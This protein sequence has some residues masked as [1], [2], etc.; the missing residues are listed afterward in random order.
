M[1]S[2]P[3]REITYVFDDVKSDSSIVDLAKSGDF[4]AIYLDG[5][6]TTRGKSSVSN[7]LKRLSATEEESISIDDARDSVG[8][9]IGVFEKV[10][11]PSTYVV[12]ADPF[13]YQPVFYRQI[14][15]PGGRTAFLVSNSFRSI[16]ARAKALGAT[17]WISW[18]VFFS[19]IGTS[20]AWSITMQSHQTLEASTFVLLPG[21]EIVVAED[22]WAIKNTNFFDPGAEDYHTLVQ[23]GVAKAVSQLKAASNIPVDQ[24]NIYLSGGRD[25]RMAI[26]LLAAAGVVTEYSVSTVNPATWTP[27]SARPGLYRDLFVANTIRESFGMNWTAHRPATN[28]PLSFQNSLEFWQSNRSHKNFRFRAQQG[29][30]VSNHIS[31]EIRGAAGETFRGFQAVKTLKSYTQF[32]ASGSTRE[33]DIHLLTEELFGQGILTGDSLSLAKASVNNS[34]AKTGGENIIDALHRRYSVYRNRSHFG[35]VKAS[36]AT[37]Q[38]PILPLSQP[39]FVKAASL[40]SEDERYENAMAFDI[41]ELA[42]PDLNTLEFDSGAYPQTTRFESSSNHRWEVHEAGAGIDAYRE[43]EDAGASLRS[44]AVGQTKRPAPFDPR[45]AAQNR[46]KELFINLSAVPEGNKWLPYALQVK[47]FQLIEGRRLNPLTLLS[48]LETTWEVFGENRSYPAVIVKDSREFQDKVPVIL[49]QD[50]PLSV[51]DGQPSFRVDLQVER[52]SVSFQ[53]VARGCLRKP[54]T[55]YARL[56]ADADTISSLAAGASG[57]GEFSDLRPRVKYRIQFFAYYEG[58]KMVPFKFFSRYFQVVGS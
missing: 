6:L 52:N 42:Y 21:E 15:L 29:L 17:N 53:V 36:M 23:Q 30:V 25:S 19:L 48:K 37:G 43:N 9:W 39:E 49:V 20:H 41:L 4:V 28:I 5:V 50:P 33:H 32:G 51:V 57:S 3:N 22:S 14:T 26:A 54:L 45:F 34:L 13:G 16:C 38:I 27:A 40:L 11:D 1:L 44:K 31:S 58:E 18:D 7:G 47:L 56:L 12:A 24:K 35:H 8:E 10:G 2:F 55:Y 46:I